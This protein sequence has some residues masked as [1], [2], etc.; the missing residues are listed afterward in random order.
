[1]FRN[2]SHIVNWDSQGD[3]TC[4][5]SSQSHGFFLTLALFLSLTHTQRGR[6]CT[7]TVLLLTRL[8]RRSFPS[9]WACLHARLFL[10]I[11]RDIRRLW[12][13]EDKKEGSV[14]P[15]SF[16]CCRL[17]TMAVPL[18][19]FKQTALHSTAWFS[20]ASWRTPNVAFFFPFLFFSPG[21]LLYAMCQ[22]H[23]SPG[24]PF[25]DTFLC[26]ARWRGQSFSVVR[27]AKI[28]ADY[29]RFP[30][31]TLRGQWLSGVLFCSTGWE[32]VQPFFETSSPTW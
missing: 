15:N 11:F 7:H 19:T 21:F 28:C 6:Q 20:W 32:I 2:K 17:V 9:V 3:R 16:L 23:V 26:F 29:F 5:M 24:E 27:V 22:L 18:L 30:L 4:F 14:C 25:S 12:K 31:V 10:C 8:P 1:M 13:R